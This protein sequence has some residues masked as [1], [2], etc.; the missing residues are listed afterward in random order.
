MR[1]TITITAIHKHEYGRAQELIKETRAMLA[2]RIG[3]LL[4][5]NYN[6][7]NRAMVTMQLLAELEEGKCV[8]VWCMCVFMWCMCMCVV[9]VWCIVIILIHILY[10]Y[11]TTTSH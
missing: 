7:A 2:D 3:E 11:P 1:H 4:T 8:Y 5:K 9:C 10:S 6:R